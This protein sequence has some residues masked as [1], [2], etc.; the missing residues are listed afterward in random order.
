ME[1]ECGKGLHLHRFPPTCGEAFS[2]LRAPMGQA[3]HLIGHSIVIVN[4]NPIAVV[5]NHG[6]TDRKWATGMG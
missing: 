5:S 4:L 3:K 6:E 1:R 2:G